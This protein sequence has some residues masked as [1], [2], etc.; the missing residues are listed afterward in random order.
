MSRRYY[1]RTPRSNNRD[2]YSV[3]NTVVLT[4]SSDSWTNVPATTDYLASRQSQVLNLSHTLE[5]SSRDNRDREL[6]SSY[7]I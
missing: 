4:P 1:R 7:S 3:E 6:S 2:K 5:I